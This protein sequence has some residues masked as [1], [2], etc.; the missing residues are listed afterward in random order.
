MS[1]HFSRIKF[2]AQLL[3]IVLLALSA[4]N[5]NIN[6]T[7]ENTGSTLPP[8]VDAGGLTLE[9]ILLPSQKSQ[10][11]FMTAGKI[12]QILVQE[13]QLVAEG[14]TLA[15]LGNTEPLQAALTQSK[16]EQLNAQKAYDD[17]IQNNDLVHSQNLQ[18][19]VT[20]EKG[21]LLTQKAFTNLDN[22]YFYDHMDYLNDILDEV[23]E[24]SSEMP[25]P[26]HW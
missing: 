15:T 26:A 18:N 1:A 10:L 9:G 5:T 14:E 7:D 17:L 25:L 8:I 16:F 24:N 23:R 3:L 19:Q 6:E 12:S 20:A 22:D 4:C 2:S 11:G 21:L 13:G